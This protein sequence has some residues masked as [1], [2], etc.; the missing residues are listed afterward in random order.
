VPVAAAV[1]D[2]DV[3]RSIST[4]S[5]DNDADR[6]TTPARRVN[7]EIASIMELAVSR[8]SIDLTGPTD[9]RTLRLL[10]VT[11]QM[12]SGN[13]TSQCHVSEGGAAGKR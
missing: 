11:R 6:D 2:D 8:W 12:K 5:W 1:G 9:S 7:P 10:P 3:L 13:E 4:V